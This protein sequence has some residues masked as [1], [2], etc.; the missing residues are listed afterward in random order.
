MVDVN[1]KLKKFI[2]DKIDSDLS[3][4]LYHPYGEELWLITRDDLQWYFS[5][6]NEGT[7]WFNQKFF[8]DFFRPF[9]MNVK[10]YPPL[11]KEWFTNK[12]QIDIRKFS[13]KNTNY[14]Y[15]V[16][17]T[18][19]RDGEYRLKTRLKAKDYDWSIQKRWGFSYPIVKRYV[20]LKESL[21]TD[22]KVKNL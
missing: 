7:A 21:Q 5:V 20:D 9:S 2:F 17:S 22:I 8:N 1:P 13:S 18:L 12:T 11:L 4:A 16:A 10:E 19:K 6:D 15:V 3:E 14:E